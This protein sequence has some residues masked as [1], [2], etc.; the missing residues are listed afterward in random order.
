[1]PQTASVTQPSSQ[2]PEGRFP[3]WQGV[4]RTKFERVGSWLGRH[5]FMKREA[6]AQSR[7]RACN[8]RLPPAAASAEGAGNLSPR[9]LRVAS[10]HRIA[11]RLSLARSG[12]DRYRALFDQITRRYSGV[13]PTALL[14]V[15]CP[16]LLPIH[17]LDKTIIRNKGESHYRGSF[18][19]KVNQGNWQLMVPGRTGKFVPQSYFDG[20][21]WR[22]KAK[23]RILRI[24]RAAGI[25][26]CEVYVGNSS[27]DELERALAALSSDDYLE[28]DQY[29]A[30]AKVLSGL[31]EYS[32]ANKG[33]EAG[34]R[35]TRMPEDV[36]RHIRPYYS[37]DFLFERDRV[38]RR[39]EVKS[40]WGT[41]TRYARLIHSKTKGYET[42]S[43]KFDTQDIFAVS[44]FLRTGNL[45]DF[46]FA[47]SVAKTKKRYGLPHAPKYP[48]YVNQNPSC[49]IGDGT[50]FAS[51]NEV[52][53]L[54]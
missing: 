49:E 21:S 42:S 37:F 33:W 27:Q 32:L 19:L 4:L 6:G 51:I 3:G 43:C 44:L 13:R 7:I 36:A 41:D 31:V 35:V 23:G 48:D 2:W 17:T 39:V 15:L 34:Y 45:D 30:A 1:M 8:V 46:A 25:A 12:A 53:N 20:S 38:A 10:R 24:D 26:Y 54:R 11:G 47:R 14:A 22:E 9:R 52:W 5:L 29:G 50:W 16:V 18:T 28:I 40:L